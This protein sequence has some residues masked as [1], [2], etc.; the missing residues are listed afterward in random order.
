MESPRC[1]GGQR[2]DTK[3]RERGRGK[4]RTE[5]EGCLERRMV[6][7]KRGSRRGERNRHRNKIRRQDRDTKIEGNRGRQRYV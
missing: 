3:P 2:R 5:T 7:T 1:G 6:E 4:R